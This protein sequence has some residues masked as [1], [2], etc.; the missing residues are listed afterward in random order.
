MRSAVLRC[1]PPTA[2]AAVLLALA[3]VAPSGPGPAAAFEIPSRNESGAPADG[4]LSVAPGELVLAIVVMR[5][6]DRAPQR[7]APAFAAGDRASLIGDR[8]PIDYA[9]WPVDYGQLTELGMEQTREIGRQLRERYIVGGKGKSLDFLSVDYKHAE[10]HVRSTDVDRT[11]VSAMNVML[12]LYE[13]RGGGGKRRAA[14]RADARPG[15]VIVPVHT[16]AYESDALMDASSRAHCPRFFAA[17]EQMLETEFCRGAIMRSTELLSALPTLTGRDTSELTFPQL[18]DLIASVRDLRVA[19]RAHGVPQPENVTRLDAALDDIVA[20]VSIAKWDVPGLGG[21]VGGRLLRAIA[22][23]M[24]AMTGLLGGDPGV[25]LH[26]REECNSKGSEEDEEGSCPRKFV[27]YVG[28]DTTIFD[29]RSALG[30]HAVVGGESG[31][32]VAAYASHVVF[33][34]RRKR[35]ARGAAGKNAGRDAS[36]GYEYMVTVL[37]GSYK[38]KTE[39]TAG[40]F[41]GG[42]ASCGMDDFLSYVSGRTPDDVDAACTLNGEAP[43]SSSPPGSRATGSGSSPSGRAPFGGVAGAVVGTMVGVVI[44]YVASVT[45]RRSDYRPIGAGR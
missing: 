21:L 13:P 36:S 27:L 6:G 22:Q 44:G 41:C 17:G 43:K 32:G 39:T 29:V 28:H 38:S 5:H 10:T 45:A 4:P 23:R 26:S 3:V 9:R 11:L 16:V 35:A 14:A 18:V 37:T 7:H 24:S 12:G 31:G 8:F 2:V 20:R 42:K 15:R 40:P 33:E 25:S 30:L 19:Q 34:L 1:S